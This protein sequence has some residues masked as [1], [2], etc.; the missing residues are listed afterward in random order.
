MLKQGSSGEDV[1]RLQEKLVAH[2]FDIVVDGFFGP[3]TAAAV[4]LFQRRWGL[5]V[6]GV[7]GENTWRTLNQSIA[8][9]PT[10]PYL[11]PDP[12]FR[13]RWVPLRAGEYVHVN[14][15]KKQI[16][17]HHTASGPDP[18]AVVQWWNTQQ[19]A[20]ATAFVIGADG[21]IVQ[22][23]DDKYWAFHLGQTSGTRVD[24]VG[25]GI[26]LCNWGFVSP[27]PDGTLRNY[28]KGVMREDEVVELA[29]PWRGFRYF[30]AYTPQQLAALEWLVVA[31]ARRWGIYVQDSFDEKW[32]ETN[33]QA[34]TGASGI[35]SHSSYRTDKTDVSPQ[36]ALIETLNRI[37]RTL[38]NT[39]K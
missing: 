27:H 10:N 37:A 1:R 16:V 11:S 5:L 26:E 8:P 13:I 25:V 6:D 29:T 39:Q 7:V 22:C 32:F 15:D 31:I 9:R 21:E 33:L 23:F 18:E 30:H 17:L 3:R 28:V 36:P 14:S 34:R 19:D 38:N 24:H 20:V 12:K 35:W 2:G 4:R